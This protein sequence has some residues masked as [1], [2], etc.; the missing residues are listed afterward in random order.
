MFIYFYLFNSYAGQL[1]LESA[2]KASVIQGLYTSV[3]VCPFLRGQEAKTL[4]TQAGPTYMYA[5][6]L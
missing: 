1:L 2:N 3:T 5:D 6:T 4:K